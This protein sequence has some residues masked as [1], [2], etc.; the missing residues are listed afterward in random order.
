MSSRERILVIDD[1]VEMGNMLRDPLTD[2]GYKVDI[3]TGGEDAIRQLRERVYDAVLSDLRMK[4]VDGL[5]VLA[6]AHKLDPQLPVLLMTA[7]GNIDSAVEAMRRGAY[8]YFTKPFRL[9]EVILYLGRALQE[10]RLRGEH[11]AL[12]QQAGLTGGAQRLVGS[13]PSMRQLRER[14]QRVADSGAP[15]L[16]RGESGTGKEL[17]A[18]AL[19]AD[20]RRAEGPF[21]AVNCT[22]LPHALL[23]SELFGHV[24]GAFT[25]ATTARRGL[26]V[27]ADRGTLFLDEIGDMPLDLQVKLLRVLDDGEVRA[28]GADGARSVDVR[29][30]AATHQDL[31]ARVNEKR[32]R[33]DLFFRLN[34]VVVRV[35]P[36]REHREDV[37]ALVEAL[38]SRARQRNPH[39]PVLSFDPEVLKELAQHS[40]PGNV[41]ELENLVERLVLLGTKQVIDLST[42]L[43]E[44]PT[45]T[46]PAP[47]S[48]GQRQEVVP[49]RQ[50]ES[51]YIAWAVARCGGNKTKAA[52]LLGID[53]ST[54]HRRERSEGSSQR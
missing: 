7:F 14:I 32:F 50:V 6:A 48:D 10:R 3:A 51:E 46:A 47:P 53:V 45:A 16:I 21:I 4:N 19:H 20:G 13:G 37:P 44:S 1:H 29:V 30:L 36:L 23:E 41:R 27:E 17:V 43:Q 26:F 54:I 33:T 34:V 9:D 2:A 52:E 12:R 5:D 40:W 11:L 42:F 22:A 15:V 31:E 8:H 39:S 28:V 24:K 38:I 25:G 49:L 18:R 35:P